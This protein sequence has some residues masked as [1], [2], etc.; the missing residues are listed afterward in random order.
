MARGCSPAA[1]ERRQPE[2]SV[3]YRTL[4]THLETFLARSS[5]EEGGG[6]PSFVTR[7]L[8]AY[9]RCGRLEHGCVHVRCEQ[10][11][12]EMVVAF[13]CKGRGFCPSCGGRRMSE[14]AAQLVDRVIP[15]V[16]VRQW[17]LSLPWSLRYQL[18]FDAA[19]YTDVLAVFMRGVF[20]GLR[21][22][23]VREG[24]AEA[25]CGAITAIQRGS[26]LNLNLH[27]HSLVLDGVY[28]RP[29]PEAAPVFQPAP[30][31]E[32]I[33]KLLERVRA[34][35]EKLLRRRGRLPEEP[36]PTDPGAEQMPL[37]AGYAAAS[38]QE[39]LATGPRAGHPVRPLR[40]AAAGGDADNPRC[41]RLAGFSPHANVS[42]AAHAR[43]QLEHRCRYLLRPPL[44][45]ERLTE[46]SGGQLLYQL[47]HP[48]NVAT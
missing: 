5:G 31:D 7:E 11:Q 2:T 22:A 15:A 9:L 26:S 8:R 34:G 44:A 46:S 45:L 14:L 48:R 37:L 39:L 42:V 1:Y 38:I 27:L 23:A 6:L 21:R 25:Q 16:P 24:I 33:A 19:L 32:E 28:T 47:P 13:S 12:L 20:A 10:C 40:S 35:V 17:V 4:E 18:A 41:A 29:A 36:S 3:L 30:T 43:E